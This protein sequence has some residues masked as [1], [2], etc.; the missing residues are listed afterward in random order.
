MQTIT[1]FYQ[2]TDAGLELSWTPA[3]QEP[4]G[5]FKITASVDQAEPLYPFDGYL[6]WLPGT[7]HTSCVV[8]MA[9]AASDRPRRWRVCSV[10]R[11]NHRKYVALPNVVI[12]PP[13]T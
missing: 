10:H 7:G 5:G 1:L 9:K 13:I 4:S 12:V 8:P 3:N 6:V 11:D 2:V